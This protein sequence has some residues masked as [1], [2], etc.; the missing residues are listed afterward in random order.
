MRR[1]RL[2]ADLEASGIGSYRAEYELG[3]FGSPRTQQAGEP[4][5]FARAQREVEGRHG[6][7]AAKPFGR[8]DLLS[9]RRGR[10]AREP[11]LDVLELASEHEGNQFQRR[12]LGG[13]RRSDQ[14]AVAQDRDAV[15]DLVDL[16]DEMGDE[17]DG[18]AA[19]FQIAHDLEQ[20]LGLVGVETGGRLV[21]H[22]DPRVVFERASDRDQLLDRHRIGAERPLDVDIELEPLEPLPRARSRASRHEIR[23]N[24]RGWR[25][26]VRFLVT[27]MVGTRLTSW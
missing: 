20:K 9:L 15:G 19:A 3:D 17:D 25:P 18:E 6:L 5:H 27:D 26:S 12:Q 13:R 2:A 24:R 11:L 4:D 22:Q 21:E 8:E 14:P 1:H 7:P 16:I 23:P 10:R